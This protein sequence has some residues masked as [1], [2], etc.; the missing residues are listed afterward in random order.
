M[1]WVENLK[2]VRKQ[3]DVTNEWISDHSGVPKKSVDRIFQGKTESPKVD[4]L[5]P[6]CNALNV[7]LD[8]ILAD[9]S[10]FIGNKTIAELQEEVNRLTSEHERINAEYNMLIAEIAMLKNRNASLTAEVNILQLKLEH[11]EE[12]LALHNYYIKMK[13][14]D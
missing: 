4:T 13:V 12:L 6:I 8:E 2:E 5:R 7:S 11:K 10:T 9:T 1:S 3:R 14:N